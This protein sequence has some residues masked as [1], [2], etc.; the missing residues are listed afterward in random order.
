MAMT[1]LT[2][3]A[4]G[5]ATAGAML[6]SAAPAAARDR[7]DR[8]GISAGEIIAGAVVIGGLA[9]ILSSGDNDRYDRYDR[10]NDR[11][12]DR[13]RGGYNDPRYGYGYDYNRYGNSRS[14][15][16]QCVSAVERGSSRYGRTDVTEVTG[17]DRKRDG[18]KIKG[19]VV[20]RDGYGGRWGRGGYYDK[21]KFSCD[22]RYGR[23]QDIRFSGL[24]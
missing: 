23:V 20:V 12:N 7:Y 4:I 13:Y 10:Y 6:M 15:V 3:A 21:G 2:K 24:R 19:R 11:Y 5:A 14:A 16:S 18:Y 1:K 9:A 17:I 22:I 8:D